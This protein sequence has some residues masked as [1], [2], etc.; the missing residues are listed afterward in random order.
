MKGATH[1]HNIPILTKLFNIKFYIYWQD[2]KFNSIG[3][4]KERKMSLRECIT[5]LE[6]KRI[7]QNYGNNF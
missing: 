3:F 5:R 1:Y 2:D 4:K 6:N 7:R